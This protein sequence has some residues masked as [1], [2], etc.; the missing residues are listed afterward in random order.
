MKKYAELLPSYLAGE[1][2]NNH[3][4]IIDNQDTQ[5]L[6]KIQLLR[7]WNKLERPI[8]IEKIQSSPNFAKMKVHINTPDSIKK[9]IVK[10]ENTPFITEYTE[11]QYITE[12]TQLY[13]SILDQEHLS[14][15]VPIK[16]T[17][18]TYNGMTYQKAYPENDIKKNNINDHDIFLDIIG[19]LLGIPRRT[20]KDWITGSEDIEDDLR[21]TYPPC[22]AKY[23]ENGNMIAGTEDDW[24]YYQRLSY[25]VENYDSSFL[26]ALMMKILYEWEHINV[27]TVYNR[28]TS[29]TTPILNSFYMITSEDDNT[30]INIDDTQRETQIKQYDILTRPSLVSYTRETVM[31]GEPHSTTVYPNYTF[32]KHTLTP[33]DDTSTFITDAPFNVQLDDMESRICY[34]DRTLYDSE[35]DMYLLPV[36]P[37]PPGEHAV[38]VQYTGEYEFLQSNSVEYDVDV[39]NEFLVLDLDAWKYG[40]AYG[41]SA[42]VFNP[43]RITNNNWLSIGRG[44]LVYTPAVYLPFI[45]ESIVLVVVF[46]YGY[47]Y[48]TLGFG[49]ITQVTSESINRKDAG[50]YFNAYDK[51]GES[52]YGIEQ[53]YSIHIENNYCYTYLNGI[54]VSQRQNLTGREDILC[55]MGY[56][57][58]TETDANQ[59]GLYIQNI[60]LTKA[61]V[62]DLETTNK[63]IIERTDK[64]AARMPELTVSGYDVGNW[65]VPHFTDIKVDSTTRNVTITVQFHTTLTPGWRMGFGKDNGTGTGWGRTFFGNTD[66]TYTAGEHE[67][68]F[69]CDDVG[70]WTALFDGEPCNMPPFVLDTEKNFAC[71]VS[72]DTGQIFIK[73]INI[74]GNNVVATSLAVE[75]ISAMEGSAEI[76]ATLAAGGS[77][78]NNAIITCKN[79]TSTVTS[80]TT[81]SNGECTLDLSSLTAGSYTLTVEYDGDSTYRS[82]STTHTITITNSVVITDD[83]TTLTNWNVSDTRTMPTITTVADK[84][85]VT[86]YNHAYARTF[87]KYPLVRGANT[88][89]SFKFYTTDSSTYA[90]LGVLTLKSAAPEPQDVTA[91]RQYVGGWKKWGTD[92]GSDRQGSEISRSTWHDITYSLE[93]DVLKIYVD[94]TLQCTQTIGTI[95]SNPYFNDYFFLGHGRWSNNVSFVIT[96][97]QYTSDTI[98]SDSTIASIIAAH[99]AQF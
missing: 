87:W 77:G 35:D 26:P 16:V 96:D 41:T 98:V 80:A 14:V 68:T 9:I 21:Y 50:M 54:R 6:H 82:T 65:H 8:L 23:D 84:T 78:I 25:F 47:K 57:N 34:S 61:R 71:Y 15:N 13:D 38:D 97:I 17:V 22:F 59:R 4:S 29:V 85:G 2:I 81:D 90:S 91:I 73:N 99:Q 43:P 92:N 11:E 46:K 24:Y 83:C 66:A 58:S 45:N 60:T 94:N 18:E 64:P 52:N 69:I 28:K 93:D 55:I 36:A 33:S 72:Y 10:V 70:T 40:K 39:A 95:D 37:L 76:Q 1:N 53:V 79:G 89:I 12:E 32:L 44:N 27:S 30:Y 3:A 7:L 49:G 75:T 20:Y 42:T 31:Q 19:D 51:L 56:S 86:P 63:K 88:T 67:I 62:M 74:G 5:I 48:S